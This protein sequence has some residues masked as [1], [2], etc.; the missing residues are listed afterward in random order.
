MENTDR[1]QMHPLGKGEAFKLLEVNAKS[2]M[3]MPEH[4]ATSEAVIVVKTGEAV[5]KM[6][7]KEQIL[8]SGDTIILPA[9]KNHSLHINKDFNAIVTLAANGEIEF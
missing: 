9:R 1:P 3:S 8:K 7:K 4:H 2:G 6:D 5:L